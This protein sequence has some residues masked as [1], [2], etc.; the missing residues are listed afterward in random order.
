MAVAAHHHESGKG[1][2]LFAHLLVA[3]SA[4]ALHVVE[5]GN[6][7]LLHEFTDF[8]MV[9]R[10]VARG[11]GYRVVEDETDALRIFY[12]LNADLFEGPRDR[13]SV[14]VAHAPVRLDRYDLVG[15]HFVSG[16]LAQRLFCKC[17]AHKIYPPSDA[18]YFAAA[19]AFM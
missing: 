10:V 6:A 8:F 14:V 7:L 18:L 4:F 3:D 11:R 16:R 13:R 12:V 1:V 9:D 19:L 15:H 5:V 2:A 17:L